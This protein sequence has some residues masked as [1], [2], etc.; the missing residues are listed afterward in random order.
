MGNGLHY[1]QVQKQ[2]FATVREKVTV[3]QFLPSGPSIF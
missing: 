3:V 2:A 1:R